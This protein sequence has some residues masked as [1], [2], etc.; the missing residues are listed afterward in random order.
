M[1]IIIYISLVVLGLSSCSLFDNEDP[2][3]GFLVLENPELITSP[4]E[5]ANTHDIKD[6]WVFVDGAFLGIYPLP[7]RVPIILDGSV[8][9]VSIF[10]GIRNNGNQSSAARYPFFESIDLTVD[11]QAQE[12]LVVPLTFRYKDN[13]VFDFVEGF[14]SNHVFVEDPNPTDGS[15]TP[16]TISTDVVKTG[17]GSGHI[18]MDTDTSSFERTTINSYS[19]L[20]NAGSSTYLEMDYKCDLS[21]LVG[22]LT[23][24]NNLITRDYNIVIVPTDEWKKIYI[25][26]SLFLSQ[27]EI[28][29]YTVQI[30]TA[31]TSSVTPPASVYLDN[32]KLIHF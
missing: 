25:D 8:K 30:A 32:I 28:D 1:K 7:A 10:A 29:A 6:A 2:I 21:F 17:T 15:G 3:P 23:Q 4:G 19:K 9:E 26:L 24:T 18:F 27:Q 20:Q 14:E 16:M 31:V 5:G 22:Y 12:E 11:L 13:I